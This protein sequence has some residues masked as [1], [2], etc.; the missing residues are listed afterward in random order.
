MEDKPCTSTDADQFIQS[1]E[2]TNSK[3]TCT[4]GGKYF[5]VPQCLN[6]SLHNPELSFHSI[7]K[8]DKLKRKWHKI[9]KTK[10]C[11]T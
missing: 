11:W 6:N 10:G 5:C 4:G 8:D 7:P 2:E 9:L 1:V 3:K